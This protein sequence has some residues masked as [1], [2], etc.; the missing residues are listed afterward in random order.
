MPSGYRK[1]A[2]GASRKQQ[3]GNA[4]KNS[5]RA[6]ASGHHITPPPTKGNRNK[7]TRKSKWS[8]Q[9]PIA[10]TLVF[11]DAALDRDRTHT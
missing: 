11:Q 4:S 9:K 10:K 3:E 8:S 7:W 1:N 6:A 5:R 2:K